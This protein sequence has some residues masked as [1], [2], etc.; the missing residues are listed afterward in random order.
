[1]YS[2][3]NLKKNVF[4]TRLSKMKTDQNEFHN[5][6]RKDK[7]TGNYRNSISGIYVKFQ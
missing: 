4:K 3:T 1:M 5:L 7:S 6:Q 2:V